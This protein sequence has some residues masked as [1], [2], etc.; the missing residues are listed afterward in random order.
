[1]RAKLSAAS[2][3]S[4]KPDPSKRLEI[5]DLGCPGLRLVVQP[6]GR[7]TWAMRFRG[8]TK[9]GAAG[10]GKLTLGG[11][12]D[13]PGIAAPK[14]GGPL[15]L[16]GAR[17]IAAEI[18]HK[19]A[20][21][22]DPI[23]EKRRARAE[24]A[25]TEEAPNTFGVRAVEFVERYAKENTRRWKQTARLLGLRPIGDRLETIPEGLADRWASKSVSAIS[26]REIVAL[27]DEC[28]F[29]SVPGL[30]RRRSAASKGEGI[31]C[32]M[33]AVLSTFFTRLKNRDLVESS[34]MGERPKAPAARDRVLTDDEIRAFWK[35][36]EGM[37]E[38]FGFVL[39][40][41]LLTGQRLNEIAGMHWSEIENG[42]TLNLGK[43]RTKN[44]CAHTLPLGP[45]AREILGSVY[46]K[47]DSPYVFTITGR[48]QVRGFAKV[49]QR[50]DALMREELGRTLNPFRLHDLRRTFITGL[51][52]LQVSRQVAEKLVNHVS[53]SFG[54]VAGVYN[55]HDYE[56]EKAQAMEAW[57]RHLLGVLGQPVE[58]KEK[59]AASTRNKS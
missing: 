39:K 13:G 16:A 56:A 27:L 3:K 47:A 46:R 48:V 9:N 18:Q 42:A 37:G 43:E 25:G 10:M 14:L 57:E 38:P 55:R 33:F 2:I 5:S 11:Y 26:K 28:Q 58:A 17:K 41:L 49:K 50:L 20:Q 4:I 40:L 35:A 29:N 30:A 59:A 45:M 12:D 51:A 21:G 24:T 23:E 22:F 44:K 54:G 7:K 52:K 8:A 36:C 6:S 1:M 53:E 34:P 31:R 15:T 19:R 32:A